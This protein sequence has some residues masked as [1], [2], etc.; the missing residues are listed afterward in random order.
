MDEVVE[1]EEEVVTEELVVVDVDAV[2]AHGS[3]SAAAVQV[4]PAGQLPRHA[5]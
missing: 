1:E 2:H 3:P 4:S 5:G